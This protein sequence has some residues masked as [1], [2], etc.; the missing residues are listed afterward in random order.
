MKIEKETKIGKISI[1]IPFNIGDK[2]YIDGQRYCHRI[3]KIIVIDENNIFLVNNY[4]GNWINI[5]DIESYKK[6]KDSY[7][8]TLKNNT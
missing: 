5:F 7:V 4:S 8:L 3:N 1:D 6:I 2:F